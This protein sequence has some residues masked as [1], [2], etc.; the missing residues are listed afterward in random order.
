MLRVYKNYTPLNEDLKLISS[1][2]PFKQNSLFLAPM[3]GVTDALY[4]QLILEE[5]NDWDIAACDFLRIPSGGTYP[6]KHL[7]KHFGQQHYQNDE[8]KKKTIYQIM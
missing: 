4:R 8:R 3:E 1:M 7:L 5:F 6:E 2:L